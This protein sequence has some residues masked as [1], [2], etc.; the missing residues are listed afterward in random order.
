MF[1]IS[2]NFFLNVWTLNHFFFFLNVCTLNRFFSFFFFFFQVAKE[3]QTMDALKTTCTY[4][5]ILTLTEQYYT[6]G[7]VHIFRWQR[8]HRPWTLSSRRTI[9]IRNNTYTILILTEQY[10]YNTYTYGT[11]LISGGKGGT[12]HGRS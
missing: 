11:I 1:A 9:L 6:Y 2:V 4:G 7:T 5:T 3:A 10:L 12:D 8:R